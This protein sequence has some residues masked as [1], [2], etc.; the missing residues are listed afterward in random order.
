M[1]INNPDSAAIFTRDPTAYLAAAGYGNCNLDTNAQEFR[2]VL[3]LSDKTVRDAAEKGDPIQFLDALRVVGFLPNS[4]IQPEQVVNVVLLVTVAVG[5]YAVVA[6]AVA[7]A[8]FYSVVV[9]GYPYGPAHD[10]RFSPAL[11]ESGA[12]GVAALL[13]GRTFMQDVVNT[14]V[15]QHGAAVIE[16]IRDGRIALPGNVSKEEAIVAIQAKLEASVL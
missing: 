11:N 4:E 6:A 8:A 12:A 1:I 3:A 16:A 5:V 15:R 9:L 14:T 13:G 10:G 7:L 2:L